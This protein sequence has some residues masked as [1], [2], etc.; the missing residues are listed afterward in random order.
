MRGTNTE[1]INR[2][3]EATAAESTPALTRTEARPL[4]SACLWGQPGPPQRLLGVD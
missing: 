3:R 1:V 4:Q 2:N